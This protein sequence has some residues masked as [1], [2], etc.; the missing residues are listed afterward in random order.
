[1]NLVLTLTNFLFPLITFPY[2]S[3][4]LLPEGTGKVAFAYAI[5]SYF[6][7]FASFGVANYGIRACAKVRD[8]KDQLSKTVQEILIINLVITL[9]VYLIFWICI[10]FIDV[11]RSERKLFWISSLNIILTVI[12]VEWLYKGLERYQYIT[13]RSVI[14]KIISLILVFTLVKS[15]NDYIIYAFVMIFATVGSGIINLLNLNR[16]ITLELYTN[17]NFKKHIKPMAVFFVTTIAVA[18]YVYVSIALLGLMTDSKEVGYYD[19][20]YRIRNVMVSIVTTLGAVL[21]PRLSYY[22]AHN[23]NDEFNRIIKKSMQF[24][25]LLSLPLVVFCFI[26]SDNIIFILAG[27]AYYS[28]SQPL[29][30][31]SFIILIVGVSNLT[32]IQMLIPLGKE[33]YLCYSVVLAAAINMLLNLILIPIYGATGT[34]ISV[35][36]A[37]ISILIYQIYILRSYAQVLFGKI[38]YIR[39]IIALILATNLSIWVNAIPNYNEIIVFFVSASLFFICYFGFL[40]ISKEPF[41]L[42]ILN[43]IKTKL[44]KN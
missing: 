26:F 41:I 15:K 32:G 44:I 37:E 22:V 28:A 2:V 18:F 39:I 35:V 7:I 20:A 8:N 13:V 30:I 4:I 24:I 9:F 27:E 11:F 34:A 17:Y 3:R 38:S 43:Q 19:V 21:L 40:F 10:E 36:L 6:S 33:K 12:G 31:L 29:K 42:S 5:V 14:F 25:F 23:M 1:M 16:L